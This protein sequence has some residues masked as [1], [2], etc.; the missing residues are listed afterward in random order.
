MALSFKAQR[1]VTIDNNYAVEIVT[2]TATE[3]LNKQIQL[4]LPPTDV[5]KVT[6]DLIGG[7]SQVF[8]VDFNVSGDILSWNGFSLETVLTAGDKIRLIYVI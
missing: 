6:L 8:G 5:N 3:A 1:V 4:Q 7:T 2:L